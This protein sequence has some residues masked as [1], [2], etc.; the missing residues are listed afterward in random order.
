MT[1]TP[2]G[3]PNHK[4]SRSTKTIQK[5]NRNRNCDWLSTSV[6]NSYN[7]S[8]LDVAQHNKVRKVLLSNGLLN[9]H[10]V[11]SSVGGGGGGGGTAI[12]RLHR[13]VPL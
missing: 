4:Q 9:G 12:Y 13:Y 11:D 10:T 1:T 6:F 2:V 7:Y 3:F 5:H 8:S